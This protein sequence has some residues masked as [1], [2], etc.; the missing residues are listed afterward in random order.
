MSDAVHELLKLFNILCDSFVCA[1]VIEG[2]AAGTEHRR[3]LQALD[4]R[5]YGDSIL[6]AYSETLTR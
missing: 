3:L 1:G 6:R 5:H 4:C 2:A